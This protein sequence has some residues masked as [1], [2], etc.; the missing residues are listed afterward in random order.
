LREDFGEEGG[1][2]VLHGELAMAVTA[3]DEFGFLAD[4]EGGTAMIARDGEEGHGFA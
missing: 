3:G 2:G 1:V 4:F